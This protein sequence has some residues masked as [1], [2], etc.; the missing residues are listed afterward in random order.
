MDSL[1]A[2]SALLSGSDPRRD[3]HAA[4]TLRRLGIVAKEQG[5]SAI[6]TAHCVKKGWAVRYP[7]D[8]LHVAGNL[9]STRTHPNVGAWWNTVSC[10][11]EHQLHRP[12][13]PRHADADFCSLDQESNHD[14]RPCSI[15][16][17][18]NVEQQG[19]G[20]LGQSQYS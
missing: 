15:F 16:Q 17:Q 4:T 13:S 6:S 1:A 12:G 3:P 5:T 8:F 9:R 18:T 14:E 20:Y 11:S 19:Q 10:D 7:R 2:V